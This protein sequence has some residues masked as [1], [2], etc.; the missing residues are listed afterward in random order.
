MGI[1]DIFKSKKNEIY[2][3]LHGL[4]LRDWTDGYKADNKGIIKFVND[5]LKKL[6]NEEFIK[7]L[8]KRDNYRKFVDQDLSDTMKKISIT[9]P[10]GLSALGLTKLGFVYYPKSC[11]EKDISIMGFRIV[12][13]N[14]RYEKGEG[15]KFEKGKTLVRFRIHKENKDTEYW[16]KKINWNNRVMSAG[17]QFVD[18]DEDEYKFLKP[19]ENKLKQ[20]KP[21]LWQIWSD[22]L[23]A[24]DALFS[25]N[26][27]KAYPI[28]RFQSYLVFEE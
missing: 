7:F 3:I 28:N 24:D 18:L 2:N 12:D 15:M 20:N 27:R 6:S 17:F 26:K 19:F 11:I 22:Y 25:T 8:K 14:V 21:N 13:T 4:D 10:K 1:F 9:E 23:E 5:K 16:D